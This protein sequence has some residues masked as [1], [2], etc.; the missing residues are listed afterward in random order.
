MGIA[1]ST[2]DDRERQEREQELERRAEEYR[3]TKRAR[4][5]RGVGSVG[6]PED[7]LQE[8]ARMSCVKT[9][10]RLCAASEEFKT[11]IESVGDTLWSELL[12]KLHP[13]AAKVAAL[14]DSPPSSAVD[15]RALLRREHLPRGNGGPIQRPIRPMPMLQDYIFSIEVSSNGVS[16]WSWA[17]QLDETDEEEAR[18]II[19][20]RTLR[21][22]GT[23][24]VKDGIGPGGIFSTTLCSNV[25]SML[26]TE[27]G[28]LERNGLI[29]TVTRRR[30]GSSAE[31]YRGSIGHLA[32]DHGGQTL[33]F[34]YESPTFEDSIKKHAHSYAYTLQQEDNENWNDPCLSIRFIIEQDETFVGFGRFEVDALLRKQNADYVHL[35]MEAFAHILDNFVDFRYA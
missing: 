32:M 6:L 34:L 14:C 9:A 25:P 11:A 15:Y 16:I 5:E 1:S 19:P 20:A 35:S 18:F 26:V 31:L 22:D 13:A 28:D 8:I 4:A 30:D 27:D 17:G 21:C 2:A 12:T 3:E 7:V 10:G 24:N 33:A 29:M 23:C